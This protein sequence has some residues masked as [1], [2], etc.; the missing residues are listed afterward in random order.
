MTNKNS[1]RSF[2]KLAALSAASIPV[3]YKI[4]GSNS[5]LAQTVPNKPVPATDAMA[6]TLGY[7]ADATKVD[8]AKFPKFKDGQLCKNCV[9]YLEGGKT[10][11]GVPGEH[12]R[13]GLFASGLVSANGWCNSYAPKVA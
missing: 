2:L 7:V 12:G 6:T 10:I 9:L 13:C 8:K 4:G 3:L 1:R 5:A 11:D